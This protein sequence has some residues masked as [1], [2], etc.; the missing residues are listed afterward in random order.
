MA[1]YTPKQYA[2]KMRKQ[3]KKIV[4]GVP[5]GIAAQTVHAD[6]VYR[7]FQK[8]SVARGYNKTDEL[9]VADKDLRR[10]GNHKG[11]TR[12]DIETTYFKSYYDLHQKQG[13]KGDN[14]IFRLKNDLQMDFANSQLDPQ[15]GK[16]DSG[17]VT[18]RSNTLYTEQLRRD[19]NVGK[20]EGLK[21]RFGDFTRFTDAERKKFFKIMEKETFRL[22]RA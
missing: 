9:W 7:I 17:K 14:V 3:L 11:K 18:K 16:A 1:T 5:L 21:K 22:L 10:A 13:F 19:E 20:L 12:K 2:I 8:G 6:R 15:T 4:E